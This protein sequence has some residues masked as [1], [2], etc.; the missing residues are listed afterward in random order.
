MFV[1]WSTLE[2]NTITLRRLPSSEYMEEQGCTGG[3][4]DSR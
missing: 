1:R 4:A 3:H 2:S